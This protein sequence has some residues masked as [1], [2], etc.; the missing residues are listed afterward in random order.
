MT[1]A[2]LQESRSTDKPKA[3]PYA[4]RQFKLTKVEIPVEIEYEDGS[5]HQFI[6]RKANGAAIRTFRNVIL[7]GAKIKD[8]KIIG[9]GNMADA[10]PTLVAACLRELTVDPATGRRLGDKPVDVH[11][12]LAW[13]Y[14][15]IKELHDT[16]KEI[17][18]MKDMDGIDTSPEDKVKR[19]RKELDEA[20]KALVES[21]ED[22]SIRKN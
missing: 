1:T 22:D 7:S 12:V 4:K 8:D 14:K 18:D 15:V 2:E 21:K 13:D 10:E 11:T 5:T 3:D 19:L 20:E 9:F 17:S 6:L 16:V